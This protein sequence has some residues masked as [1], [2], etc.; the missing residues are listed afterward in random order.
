MG[1]HPDLLA[2]VTPAAPGLC[3]GRDG[4]GEPGRPLHPRARRLRPSMPPSARGCLQVGDG[5]RTPMGAEQVDGGTWGVCLAPS[6]AHPLPPACLPGLLPWSC[7]GGSGT[8]SLGSWSPASWVSG[9]SRA[10]SGC[11]A[12][13]PSCKGN[14]S[15]PQEERVVGPIWADHHEN[16]ENKPVV[17]HSLFHSRRVNGH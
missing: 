9:P 3:S 7:A 11:P 6:P 2:Q 1:R 14:R 15:E 8:R 4:S 12:L 5:T 16:S 10:G 13:P 17:Y